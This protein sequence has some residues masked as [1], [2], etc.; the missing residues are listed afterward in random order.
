MPAAKRPPIPI[1]VL[2]DRVLE[3]VRRRD[4]FLAGSI[5]SQGV[6]WR[7]RDRVIRVT[8]DFDVDDY[9]RRA[10]EPTKETR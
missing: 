5:V 2:R 6:A 8:L 9:L 10:N 4:P 7:P 1:S 3:C